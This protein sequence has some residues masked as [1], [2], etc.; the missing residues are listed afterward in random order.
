MKKLRRCE[1]CGRAWRFSIIPCSEASRAQ[2][3]QMG[4]TT[5][6]PVCLSEIQARPDSYARQRSKRRDDK[7]A[8]T[9]QDC[10]ERRCESSDR[11]E[12]AVRTVRRR[13]GFPSS[14]LTGSP[15][16]RGTGPINLKLRYS[17]RVRSLGGNYQ[18]RPP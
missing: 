10:A 14:L 6:D 5:L 16:T 3:R 12:D 7:L 13:V 18:A 1:W 8:S 15:R 2:L 11:K 4:K 17:C 9:S